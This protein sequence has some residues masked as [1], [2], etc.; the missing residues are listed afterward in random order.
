MGDEGGAWWISHKAIK[1]VFDVKDNFK[2]CEHSID[3]VWQLT[4]EHFGIA[5]RHDLLDHCYGK[6]DKPFFSSL[7]VKLARAALEG[8]KL[9]RHVFHEAGRNLA[10]SVIALLPRVQ[11]KLTDRG[12]LY[13]VCVGS[14]WLSWE[15]LK[16][17]FIQELNLKNIEYEIKLLKLNKTMALGA[18]YLA[19]DSIKLDFPRDYQN[20][21]EEFYSYSQARNQ[22]NGTKH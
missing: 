11:N 1:T 19:A 4:K 10:L 8:D 21:Y 3:T 14:V 12:E 18:C 9:S 20:N 7:C 13:I 2:V 6:F 22:T 15:L 17:G 16:P 5:N